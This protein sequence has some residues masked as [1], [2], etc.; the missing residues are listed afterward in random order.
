MSAAFGRDAIM[1][2]FAKRP[3]RVVIKQIWVALVRNFMMYY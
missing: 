3:E 2:S 1:A